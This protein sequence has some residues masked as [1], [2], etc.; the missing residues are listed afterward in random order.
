MIGMTQKRVTFMPYKLHFRHFLFPLSEQ[1]PVTVMVPPEKTLPEVTKLTGIPIHYYEFGANYLKQF[2]GAVRTLKY[3]PGLAEKLDAHDFDV[4]V[5]YEY[6]HWYTMQCVA[7]KK[8]NPNFKLYLINE[9]KR[10]PTNIVAHIMKRILLV[11]LRLNIH[12]FE[13]VFVYTNT[14]AEWFQ[15]YIPGS[16]PILLPTPTNV[17]FYVPDPNRVFMQDGTLRLLMNARYSAYKRH[18][19]IFEALIR[20]RD[21]GRKVHL[22]CISREELRK[23]EVVAL[24]EQMGVMDMVTFHDPVS[25]EGVVPLNHAHDMLV[26]PSYNE[27]IGMVVPEA[28]ACGM[29]TITTDTVGANVYV[30]D[31]VTGFI[32]PTG[33]VDALVAAIE[34]SY[35]PLVLQK[36]GDAAHAR[37]HEQFTPAAVVRQFRD[38]TGV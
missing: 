26:L 29:P 30:E 15:K 21:V 38:I 37:I 17:D 36:M 16:N 7:Y 25:V 18:K 34:Q 27:A 4:L 1:V 33:D 5:T 19:D 10:W 3:A 9:T 2:V 6:Y 20:L 13:E 12:H 23:E 22:T 28:M 11:W 35:D 8:R 14:A 32:Y 31:G 24:A